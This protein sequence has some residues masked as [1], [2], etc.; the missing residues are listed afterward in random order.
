MRSTLASTSIAASGKYVAAVLAVL[1]CLSAG[2]GQEPPGYRF[3][4]KVEMVSVFVTVEDRAGRLVT[5]LGPQDFTV[6]DDG[7]SQS[8]SQFS[9]EYV[10]LSVLI[11]LDSSSSMR[12]RKLENAKKALLQFLRRLRQSDEA[13]LVTFDTRLRVLQSFTDEFSQLRREL[14]RLDGNGS[15]ALYDAVLSALNYARAA[16]NRRRTLLLISDGINNYGRARLND[17]LE[18]LRRSG[19]EL[20][21]IG[22][23]TDLPEDLQERAITQ[24]VL[25]QLTRA[26]GGEFFLVSEARELERVCGAISDRMHNQYTFGYYP[27]PSRDGRWR[28]VRIETRVPG[29]RIIASKTGYYPSKTD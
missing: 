12:G 5:G 28:S 18:Q 6:Y 8:I 23:E 19:L 24:A 2:R 4:V 16:R 1:G 20:F 15:T 27:P 3:G 13:M 21:A 10:P 17:T 9:R 7:V 25:D 26:A 14:K 11:L 29:L 22:L